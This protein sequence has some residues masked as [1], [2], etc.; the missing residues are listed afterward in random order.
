MAVRTSRG[1]ANE[2]VGNKQG[3]A[4]GITRRFYV[5]RGYRCMNRHARIERRGRMEEKEEGKG[6]TPQTAVFLLA[7]LTVNGDSMN[8]VNAP[9][10]LGCFSPSYPS[11]KDVFS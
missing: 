10:Y 3:E 8:S 6:E 7:T 5:R 9:L 11:M 1:D 2:K 4:N